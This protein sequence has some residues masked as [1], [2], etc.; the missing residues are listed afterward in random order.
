MCPRLHPTSIPLTPPHFHRPNAN[1]GFLFQPIRFTPSQR[2]WS[3]Y[4]V[5]TTGLRV[6]PPA[7]MEVEAGWKLSSV[8]RVDAEE[9]AASLDLI[10]AL[11]DEMLHIIIALVPTK[12][13]VCTTILSKRW[14]H[15]W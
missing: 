4:S 15:L 3:R 13:A 8:E 12:S 11:T 10:S 5:E 7:E 9:P 6:S 1:A 14:R 2:R